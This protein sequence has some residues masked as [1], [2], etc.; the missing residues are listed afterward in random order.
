MA[1]VV[2]LTQ[3]LNLISRNLIWVVLALAISLEKASAASSQT[4]VIPALVLAGALIMVLVSQNVISTACCGFVPGCN[5]GLQSRRHRRLFMLLASFL[6]SFAVL[7]LFMDY[8]SPLE[9][10]AIYI[11]VVGYLL[12]FAVNTAFYCGVRH[13]LIYAA[14]AL[15]E[16]SCHCM[17]PLT[18][19]F[20]QVLVF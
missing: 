6:I 10:V 19:W 7:A 16:H 8:G 1:V 12:A 2:S 17:P 9:I 13:E 20:S 18:T 4:I 15:C 3:R 14:Y 5:A 11:S